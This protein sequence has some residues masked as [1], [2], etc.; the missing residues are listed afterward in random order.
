MKAI[1]TDLVSLGLT[2]YQ[3]KIYVA[4]LECQPATAYEA[5][6]HSGVPTSRVYQ[7]ITQLEEDRLVKRVKNKKRTLYAAVESSKLVKR[8]RGRY[9]GLLDR[10]E[11]NLSEK[12]AAPVLQPVWNLRDYQECI[13]TSS[14]IIRSAQN[15]LLI[16]LWRAEASLLAGELT[17]A[18]ERGVRVAIIHFGEPHISMGRVF[19]HP[20][21]QTL[22]EEKGGRTLTVTADGTEA[23]TSTITA[24][25]SVEGSWG[26]GS[27]LVTLAEDYI[28]HDIYIMKIVRRFSNPLIR[29]FGEKYTLLR[30][31]F[32]DQETE[33]PHD[34][35]D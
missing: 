5:A 9:T 31:I 7:V 32:N 22:A 30:D 10:L 21:S 15:R 3:A 18:D 11:K 34:N 25:N 35:L 17:A 19:E 29:R 20:I 4:L 14:R 6:V 1:V 8:Q 26:T 2:E 16:S 27:G 24:G 28:R 33:A 23:L 13:E 12:E